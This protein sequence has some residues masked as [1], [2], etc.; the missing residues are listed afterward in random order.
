MGRRLSLIIVV[1]VLLHGYVGLRLIPALSDTAGARE[2]LWSWLLLSCA[3][4]IF[5]MRNRRGAA[6]GSR[7]VLTWA[8]L[9]AMGFFS[10]LLT[11]TVIRDLLLGG[12]WLASYLPFAWSRSVEGAQARVAVMHSSALCVVIVAVLALMKGVYNARRRAPVVDVEIPIPN[13]PLALDGFTIVQL[14]D[15]HVGPTIRKRYI[16]AIVDTVVS[17]NADLV[18]I[19]G[20]VVDGSVP[21]LQRHTAP[22]SRLRATHGV[23][24]VT[25]NH[26]YYAGADAW[27]AEFKRLGLRVLLNEHTVIRVGSDALVLAG[28]TDFSGEHFGPS[29]R[30]DPVQA[31]DGA[32][33][34]AALRV[35]LAHQPRTGPAADAAGFDVQLSGHTHGGQIFP[36]NFAVPLQ[37]P[38]TAGLVRCGEMWMYVSRGTGYAGPPVRFGA[39]S[40][41]TRIRLVRR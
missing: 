7:A 26:E 41:I 5:G 29:H 33:E 17:L 38:F 11:S 36:W 14:S 40:E 4:I 21:N 22:L 28:V 15:I 24:L 27:I 6:H 12:Y 35:L 39:P 20:D 23:F 9:I 37:Q 32:P 31:L 34:S 3:V 1:G 10:L 2:A 18:A 19:T 8:A 13:L 30:S 25:G 16:D